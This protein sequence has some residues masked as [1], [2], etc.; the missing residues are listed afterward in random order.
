MREGTEGKKA[1]CR[2][3]KNTEALG[4]QNKNKKPD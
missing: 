2:E 1:S 3:K 4:Q